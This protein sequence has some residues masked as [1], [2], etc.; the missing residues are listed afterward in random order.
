MSFNPEPTKQPQEMIFSCKTKKLP[1]PPLVF[2]NVNVTQSIYQKHQGIILD[3]KLTFENHLNMLTTK[4]NKTIRLRHKLQ[5]FLSRA[6]LIKIYKAFIKL[7][8]D[9]V[10]IL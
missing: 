10:N 5:N 4:I 3:S 1:H 8:L 6:A 7:H 9:Y 2:N